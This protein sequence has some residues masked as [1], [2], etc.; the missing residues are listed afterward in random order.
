MKILHLSL[1][2]EWYE[3]IA[4]GK[5]PEEYREF[6]RYWI[7]RLCRNVVFDGAMCVEFIVKDFDAVCFSY[8]YSRRRMLWECKGI[9]VGRGRK[10]WGAPEY[11]TFIIKLGRR[12]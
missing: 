3:M 6:V 2:K 11:D 7:T 12:L 9:E 10:E 4:Q 8:G 1:K 5:K